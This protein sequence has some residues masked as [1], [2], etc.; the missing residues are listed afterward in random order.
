MP[1]FFQ[2][3][4]AFVA[5]AILGGLFGLLIGRRPGFPADARL[6]NE[7]R[8]QLQQR[9]KELD[10]TR[11][12]LSKSAADLATAEANCAAARQTLAETRDLHA[13]HLRDA[14][15]TQE[16][17]LADLRQTFQALSA[18]ALRQNA[19]QFLQL[20]NETFA[21]F[22][23]TA[24]GDLSTLVQPL[25]EQLDTYQKRLQQS[26]SNQS[27]T[28]GEVKKQLES[29]AQ[30]SQNL[31]SE[32]LQLRRV[33]SSN[34]AR[35][36][37][38][39]ETLRR[40][41]EAAG[42]SPHCDFTEQNQVDDKK[43]DLIVRLPGDRII[44][45]DSKVPDLDFLQA[46]DTADTVQRAQ[47][48]DQHAAKLKDTI[49][50]L[51]KKDYPAQYPNALDYVVLFVPAES[52][53]SAALEADHELIVWASQRKIMLATPTSL[54]ALLRA[55]SVSWQQHAQTENA[56]EIAASAQ[57]LFNRVA[58]FFEHFEKI[59]AGLEKAT[60]SFNDAV[61][62]Y[63]RMVR[64]SGEKLIKLS[65]SAAAKNLGEIAPL[66]TTL[67]LPPA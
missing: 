9:E 10:S 29:L 13:A 12:Q 5:G 19:P 32:T 1:L 33:L 23:E 17:A 16:K 46:I 34:Q 30:N 3:A 37:W 60:G 38:G 65:G 44:I 57:E 49:R 25:R 45:V 47:A 4:I 28:L 53:F 27:T 24:K 42:M 15:E 39:E 55:V 62:S 20:A 43:P 2:L 64:P 51:A 67:R 14:R 48:L 41:V 59:R 50:D 7:L 54:I 66:D 35:G 21:K 8:Q 56:R 31:S 22:Q 52:L 36:R 63:D 26:E 6:E 40:V 18:D 61:G 58:K 11:A